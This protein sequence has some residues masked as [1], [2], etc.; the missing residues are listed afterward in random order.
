MSIGRVF[1]G[2]LSLVASSI[3]AYKIYRRFKTS[4]RSGVGNR[5]NFEVTTY[6]RMLLG[7]SF[8]DILFSI[9]SLGG[10]FAVPASTGVVF[11]H[12]TT[13]TCSAQGFLLQMGAALPLYTACLNTF[14]MLKIRYN[15][16]DAV[17]CRRYE[18]W[19]HGIP[20]VF[21]LS[22]GT[23]GVL[24]KI[25]N[26]INIPEMGCWIAPYP[27]GC[28]VSGEC[29]RGYKIA[30][31]LDLY[32]WSFAYGVFFVAFLVV[33]F[34]SILIYKSLLFQERRNAL[35]LGA[36]LQSLSLQSDLQLNSASLEPD[37]TSQKMDSLATI[38]GAH[39]GD[40]RDESTS[41]AV[42]S[43]QAQAVDSSQAQSV[44]S[45]QDQAVDSSQAKVELPTILV[46]QP[47]DYATRKKRLQVPH[48][49]RNVMAGPRVRASRVAAVQ[50]GLYCF[51]TFMTAVWAFVPWLG[52]KIGSPT[53][54][55]V[56]YA[57]MSGFV[58]HLQG[59]FNLYIFVRLQ[60]NRIRQTER[61]WNWLKCVIHCL[62]SPA[63]SK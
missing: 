59:V 44:D 34:T 63:A 7:I 8:L 1:A 57:F 32:A 15:V 27:K 61:D 20:I 26:P 5:R 13:A 52:W 11:G 6:H 36:S 2:S 10:T 31:W 18:P 17:V 21:A 58:A 3:I 4:R 45:S 12:G 23:L 43:S 48:G 25:F 49:R 33:L 47:T 14:F 30:E 22:T 56:F 39:E 62:T 24:L 40:R 9:G 60:F 19:F 46:D 37:S 42:D 55:R 50:S 54:I 35:Y 41:Q 53:K 29:T 51:A 16:S 38:Q 28:I